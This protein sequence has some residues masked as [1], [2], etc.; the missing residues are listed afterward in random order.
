MHTAQPIVP[1]P[2]ASEVDF[3]VGKLKS[4]KSPGVEQI[5]SEIFRQE[6][7]YCVRKF[8]SLLS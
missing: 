8:I 7:K 6:G 2:S 5:P 4:Y 3:A 1:K